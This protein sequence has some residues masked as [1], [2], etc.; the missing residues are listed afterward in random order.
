M[1]AREARRKAEARRRIVETQKIERKE[2]REF[3]VFAFWVMGLFIAIIVVSIYILCFVREMVIEDNQYSSVE[4]VTEWMKSDPVI[5]NSV[6]TY[7]KYNY[8]NCE[9]PGTVDDITIEFVSP[10]SII[11]RV[12]DKIPISG[13][14]MGSKYVY[15][16]EDGTVVLET[17]SQVDGIALIEGID[18]TEYTIYEKIELEDTD[19]FENALEVSTILEETGLEVD[20]ISSSGGASITIT[21][22]GIEILLGEGTYQEKIAQ[23]QPIIENLDG[24]EGVLD[25]SNFSTTNTTISFI[26]NNSE[27]SE[28]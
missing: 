16:D 8:T 19:I 10:W 11:V 12:T 17:T 13:F 26:R 25:L 4:V 15:C 7:I 20:T 27:N 23:I 3:G 22:D 5:V 24:E 6:A 9:L 2:R 18:V 28:N 14:Q 1:D 21:I